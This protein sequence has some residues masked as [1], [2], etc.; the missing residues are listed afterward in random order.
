[1]N[2]DDRPTLMISEIFRSL[3]GESTFAGLPCVFVRLSGC[4]LRCS[5]CDTRYALGS[6]NPMSLDEIVAKV[7]SMPC[8]I[9]EITGGEP[10]CQK[11]TPALARLLLDR[12]YTV[13]VE[14]NGSLDVTLLPPGCVI[15]M[16]VKCPGSGEVGKNLPGNIEALGPG[17]QVK[18]VLSGREDYEWARDFALSRGLVAKVQPREIAQGPPGGSKGAN[19][20]AG[21]GRSPNLEIIFSPAI[22]NLEPAL[23]AEWILDDAIEVRLQVQ[24]HKIAGFR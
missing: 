24:L 23:L 19:S 6:G 20:C 12:G 4:N 16:D 1:M 2:P 11:A 3:Q 15:V 13:L 14:T 5:Y 9:V 18:F 7:D 17:D 8:E 10:L 22:G 21:S